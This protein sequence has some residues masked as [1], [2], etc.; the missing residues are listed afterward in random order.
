MPRSVKDKIHYNI[1]KND[2][3]C[4]NKMYLLIKYVHNFTEMIEYWYINISF[5]NNKRLKF[6]HT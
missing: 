2:I 1:N 3:V 4:I 5:L 6:K